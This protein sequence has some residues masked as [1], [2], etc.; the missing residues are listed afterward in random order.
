MFPPWS[1]HETIR[2]FVMWDVWRWSFWHLFFVMFL[3]KRPP[4]LKNRNQISRPSV[5]SEYWRCWLVSPHEDVGHTLGHRRTFPHTHNCETRPHFSD[6]ERKSHS[7]MFWWGSHHHHHFLEASKYLPVSRWRINL[8]NGKSRQSW[9]RDGNSGHTRF[10]EEISGCK[11]RW[12]WSQSISEP[13][14]QPSHGGW[15][16]GKAAGSLRSIRLSVSP[17]LKR[18][19]PFFMMAHFPKF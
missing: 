6:R 19:K 11:G 14:F 2:M 10:T 1:D 7:S 12:T 13:P 4:D 18:I 9:T 8:E 17:C 5:Y 3:R 15:W 16:P